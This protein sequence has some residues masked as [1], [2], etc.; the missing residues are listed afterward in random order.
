MLR[1]G[2]SIWKSISK[3]NSIADCALYDNG[4]RGR[5]FQ[6]LQAG[7]TYSMMKGTGSQLQSIAVFSCICLSLSSED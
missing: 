7:Q 3:K 6:D 5:L 2:V 4:E 1:F